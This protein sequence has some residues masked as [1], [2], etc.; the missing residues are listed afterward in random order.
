V[1]WSRDRS[2]REQNQ[3]HD[4]SALEQHRFGRRVF[5]A[6]VGAGLSSLVWGDA[7]W[8]RVSG[9]ISPVAKVVLPFVPSTG[10]RIYAIA[11]SLPE[12]DPAKWT[13]S[14]GGL[15][16]R[17]I[18]ITYADVRALPHVHQVSTFH[19]VTGWTVANVHWG[20]VRLADVISPAGPLESAHAIQFISAEYPYQDYLTIEQASLPDV[21]LADEM[22]GRPLT[23]PHG[24]PLRL[25]IP[26]MYGYKGVKWIKEIKLAPKPELGY[27]EFEGYDQDA[28]IRGYPRRT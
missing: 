17:P 16:A 20:G 19:C 11:G 8:Q 10:W 9:V 3:L 23:R 26:E 14:I 12:F 15:V 2:R 24:A 18:V 4:D 1:R 28:W 13:L 22:D 5:L 27:W 21:I 7:V 25:V 6:A